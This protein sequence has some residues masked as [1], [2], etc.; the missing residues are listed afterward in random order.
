MCDSYCDVN[1]LNSYFYTMTLYLVWC[2]YSILLHTHKTRYFYSVLLHTH[3]IIDHGFD[4][5]QKVMQTIYPIY[6]YM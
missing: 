1:V 6:V 5:T 3:G 2:S 4:C